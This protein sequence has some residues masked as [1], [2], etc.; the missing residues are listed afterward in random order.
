MVGKK[1][2]DALQLAAAVDRL[3]ARRDPLDDARW[4][5][6]AKE[7][8]SLWSVTTESMIAF[9]AMPNTEDAYNKW[10]EADSTSIERDSRRRW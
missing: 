3:N 8:Q 6:F 9:G 10:A 7:T 4:I 5:Y 2:D 1:R